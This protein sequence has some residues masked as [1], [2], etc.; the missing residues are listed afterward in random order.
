MVSRIPE[1]KG[2]GDRLANTC[3]GVTLVYRWHRHSHPKTP[4]MNVSAV[5]IKSLWACLG[6]HMRGWDSYL[7]NCCQYL[8]WLILKHIKQN[9]RPQDPEDMGSDQWPPSMFSSLERG[10]PTASLLMACLLPLEHCVLTGPNSLHY[11]PLP[12]IEN[13]WQKF[14]EIWQQYWNLKCYCLLGW[15]KTKRNFYKLEKSHF[16]SLCWGN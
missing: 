3:R 6:L 1:R 15:G 11:V 12:C 2:K 7:S 9:K 13:I 16:D 14:L 10:N 4:L 5:L 8:N